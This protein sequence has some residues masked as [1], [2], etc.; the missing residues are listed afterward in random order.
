MIAANE[1][2]KM[3]FSKGFKSIDWL[4]VDINKGSIAIAEKLGFSLECKY[5]AFTPYPPVENL[6]DLS[7][8]D[9]NDWAAYFE[10][11]SLT[12][13]QLL[14]ECLFAYIK[15]NNVNKA[16]EVLLIHREKKPI[17][18]DVD[19]FIQYLHTIGMAADFPDNWMNTAI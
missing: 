14:T 7:E 6:T 18:F 9:W 17:E 4:C 2:V 8:T 19:G 11:A 16:N 1:T 12:E 15:A 3:C 13:P 10:N 5:D